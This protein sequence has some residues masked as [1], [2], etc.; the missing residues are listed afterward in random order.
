MENFVETEKD[1][2]LRQRLA[3]ALNGRKPFANFNQLV[4]NLDVREDWFDFR[5]VA[6]SKMA[7]E[8]IKENASVAL[9]EKIKALPTVRSVE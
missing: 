7:R 4:H 2:Y 1:K 8:W 5:D 6:Y 9:E 3:D